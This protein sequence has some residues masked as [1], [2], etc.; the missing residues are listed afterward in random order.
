MQN[1]ACWLKITDIPIVR[2]AFTLTTSYILTQHYV[3]ASDSANTEYRKFKLPF[4][5]LKMIIT[6]VL[7]FFLFQ[8]YFTSKYKCEL[9]IKMFQPEQEYI[10]DSNLTGLWFRYVQKLIDRIL[11]NEVDMHIL[12]TRRSSPR[13]T[14][15]ITISCN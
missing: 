6:K 2:I 14:A 5:L 12:Q 7:L 3:S 10:H 11:N 1:H 4:K 8:L 9:F 13:N 15:S